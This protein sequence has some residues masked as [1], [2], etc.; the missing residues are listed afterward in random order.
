[1]KLRTDSLKKI[2]KIDKPLSRLTKKKREKV[3]VDKIKS[4]RGEMTTDT[5]E[6]QRVIREYYEQ[7]Y[8]NI[9]DNLEEMGQILRIIQTSKTESGRNRKSE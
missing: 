5:I 3:L 4:V 6:M 7:L 2:N 9:L 1:M 8:T